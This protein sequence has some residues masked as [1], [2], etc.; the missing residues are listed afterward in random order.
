MGLRIVIQRSY[1]EIFC[2]HL[3]KSSKLTKTAK[4]STTAT[5]FKHYTTLIASTTN[6]AL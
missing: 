4:T 2:K 3:S 5:H 6:G 1:G